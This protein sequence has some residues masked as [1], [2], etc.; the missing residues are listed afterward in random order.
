MKVVVAGGTG[1]VGRAVLAVLNAAGTRAIAGSPAAGVNTISGIG[2]AA[3]LT[4][5]GAVLD[6]TRPGHDDQASA[7]A[8]FRTSTRNLLIAEMQTGTRHHVVLSVLGADHVI[9][10]GYYRAKV[11]QEEAAMDGA[12][13]ITIVRAAPTYESLRETIV[14][15]AEDGAVRLPPTLI[16]PIAL[17]DLVTVL[18]QIVTG[19]SADGVVELAGPSPLLLDEVGRS[20]LKADRDD[21]AV[22]AGAGAGPFAGFE[23][24]GRALLPG[25]GAR[26][27]RTELA[28]WLG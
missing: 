6:V 3:A 26:L 15:L 14:S 19:P 21:A 2:L 17:A 5:A 22:T 4:G 11:A 10:N 16:Q 9:G 13:P 7:T 18:A 24:A 28:G 8:F 23:G 25:A 1:Q 20:I 27:G 12:V